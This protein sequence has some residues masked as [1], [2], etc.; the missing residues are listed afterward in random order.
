M[1]SRLNFQRSTNVIG[2]LEENRSKIPEKSLVQSEKQAVYRDFEEFSI[3]IGKLKLPSSWTVLISSDHVEVKQICESTDNHDTLLPYIQVFI[4]SDL[5]YRIRCYGWTVPI[6]SHIHSIYPSF[7]CITLSNFIKV[8]NDYHLCSGLNLVEFKEASHLKHHV[9]P[10][11]F[12][13]EDFQ[14]IQA[15][16]VSQLEYIRSTQCHVLVQNITT[17]CCLCKKL[18]V[19]TRSTVN[20]KKS[21]QLIPAKVQAPIKFTSPER[22]KLTMQSFRI[23]NK[24]L[25]QKVEEISLELKQNSLPIDSSLSNDLIDIFKGVPQEKIPPFMRLFWEEQQKYINASHASQIRYHPAVIKYCLAIAAKSPAAYDQLR[26]NSKDGTGVL[27]LP[28]QRTLRDYRNYIR[29]KQGFN[30]EVIKEFSQKTK[31]F[32]SSELFVTLLFDEMKVQE[33]LVWDKS[34][35]ELIGFV[36]LGDPNLNESSFKSVSKLATHILV[37]MAKS[38]KNPLSFSIANFATD[39]VSSHQLYSLFLKAVSVLELS[40]NM[41]VIATVSDGASPNR[42]FVR[43]N[44]VH[45]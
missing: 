4:N 24:S 16:P 30:P 33:D 36:N 15:I 17:I 25:K 19:K 38:V 9:I 20:F 7:K 23:E 14:S 6:E 22:I 44:K 12:K 26:L 35:G 40:C 39:G 43:M 34:T 27:V 1:P 21:Q 37:F 11:E 5:L 42:K 31:D 8:L 29:P 10:K 3:R 28:S 18:E 41:K 13:F 45:I 32:S 2:K